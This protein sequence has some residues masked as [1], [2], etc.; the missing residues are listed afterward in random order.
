MKYAVRVEHGKTLKLEEDVDA[1]ANGGFRGKD[2]PRVQVE[3]ARRIE[4]LAYYQERL[5]AEQQ[6][7]LL[8]VLQAMDT[9]GKDGVLRHVVGPLDSRGVEV[10]SFKAPNSEEAAHDFLWRVHQKAPRKGQ[11]AFFNRSHYEDVLVPRV[12]KLVPKRV[13]Q[14]RYEHIN[15]FEAMLDDAG[16]RVLKIFLHI[17]RAEQKQRLEER[18]SD[19]EKHWKFDEADLVARAHWD[20]YMKAY[21]DALSA[22]STQ[23]APWYIV[24]ANRKWY[25]NLAVAYVLEKTL[26][27]MDPKFPTREN[28]DPKKFVIPE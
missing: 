17:S 10:V 3:L 22:C 12:M 7:A 21:A 9:A 13:W 8:V 15:A 1:D 23:R 19:P 24:P 2:D 18:L 28:F 14:R 4:R 26:E 5:L 6:R 20:D 16:I 11:I 25:R 27:D